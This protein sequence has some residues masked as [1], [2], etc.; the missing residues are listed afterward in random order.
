MSDLTENSCRCLRCGTLMRGLREICPC[1]GWEKANAG[2][3]AVAAPVESRRGSSKTGMKICPLCLST[4]PEAELSD[5]GGQKLCAVC[6]EAMLK[7]ANKA[8]APQ[9]PAAPPK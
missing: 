4:V 9:P 7:K 6:S 2:A 3:P 1:C 5:V 8:S